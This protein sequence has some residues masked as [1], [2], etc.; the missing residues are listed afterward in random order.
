MKYILLLL[1]AIGLYGLYSW[2]RVIQVAKDANLP[3]FTQPETV[4]GSGSE[5]RYIAA[6]DSTAEGVGA[7]SFEKSYTYR[8][9]QHWAQTNSVSYK[10]VGI[11]GAQTND[12]LNKQLKDIIDFKPDVITLSI[13]ANDRTH[14]KSNSYILEN[15]KSII[16]Q[17][18]EQTSATI[19]ITDIPNF[20]NAKLL[21]KPF[22]YYME[23]QTRKL[24]PEIKSLESDRVKIVNIHDFGWSTYPDL[25]ITFA[26]DNFHPNDEGYNNWT[27]AFLDRIKNP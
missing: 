2:Y 16:K 27:N 20:T 7:S 26:A 22:I 19:Y 18:T 4:L 3:V 25:S 15:Y 10:N 24:N 14:L 12:I 9:A 21:P 6:G 23:Q 1:L 17:I 11:L 8:L 5:L 13:G